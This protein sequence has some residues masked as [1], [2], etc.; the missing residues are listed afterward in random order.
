MTAPRNQ[1]VSPDD[2]YAALMRLHEGRS[3]ADS[4][5]LNARLIL[6]LI[7]LVDDKG[8]VMTA[9]AAAADRPKRGAGTGALLH[10]IPNV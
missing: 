3:E 8:T 1:P 7:D 4:A 6:L 5:V 10:E 9:V 2:I